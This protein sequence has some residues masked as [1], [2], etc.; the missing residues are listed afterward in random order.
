MTAP[1]VRLATESDLPA[2]VR[3]LADDF[4]GA[5]RELVSDPVAEGYTRAFREISASAATDVYV[6]DLDGEVIGTMQI[7]VLPGLSNQGAL[8]LD[9]EAVRVDSS[10]RSQGYGEILIRWAIDHARERGCGI[11]QLSSNKARTRAHQ[12]YLRLG[13][14]NSHEGFKLKLG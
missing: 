13:F 1:T 12:F 9:I 5:E 7:S 11:V 3:L 2:V 10:L 8:R 14:K 6:L 4:L